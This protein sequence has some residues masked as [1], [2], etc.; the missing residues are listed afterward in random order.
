VSHSPLPLATTEASLIDPD[1]E[2]VDG[3]TYTL[4]NPA[5]MTREILALANEEWLYQFH[6]TR[7]KPL[8]RPAGGDT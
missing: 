3:T 7:L 2:G 4:K 6:I 5:L 8:D 1:I